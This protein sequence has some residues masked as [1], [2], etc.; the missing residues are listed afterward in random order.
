MATHITACDREALGLAASRAL[1][2]LQSVGKRRVAPSP[3][4]ILDLAQLN[5]PLP[6]LPADAFC[7]LDLWEPDRIARPRCH[8]RREV[9][10]FCEWRR[11]AGIGRRNLDRQ[12]LG[13]ECGLA[14]DVAGTVALE[15]GVA[16]RW[17]RLDVWG[18]PR[19]AA[20]RWS[21]AATIANLLHR[22]GR[23][24]SR[25]RRNVAAWDVENDGMFGAPP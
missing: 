13:S 9:L 5:E 23:G 17:V 14:R 1:A 4:A 6:E 21:Q 12:R 11:A 15:D 22:T 7:V 20:D 18:F 24:P 8:S 19:N 10:W 3:S 25:L 16:L 2:Y